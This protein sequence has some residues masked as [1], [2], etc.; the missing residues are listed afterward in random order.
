MKLR[1][2]RWIALSVALG[3]SPLSWFASRLS[4]QTGKANVSGTVRDAGSAV[5]PGANVVITNSETGVV[6][7][8]QTNDVGSY[9]LGALPRGPYTLVVEKEGFKKWTG[10]LEL[11]VGQNAVVDAVLN[12]GSAQEVVSVTGSAPVITTQ[13][14]EVSNVKDYERIRQLPLNGREITLLLNLTPGVEGEGSC[15]DRSSTAPCTSFRVN[16]SKVG[17]LDIT[18]DGISGIDRFGGGAARIEPGLDT[19]QEFRIETA[20]SDASYSRPSTVTIST[21]S[22]TNIFH[23]SLFETHRNNS[24]GLRVRRR[25]D[26]PDPE[27]GV[28]KP[29]QL[30]RNEYGASA[31]GPLFIPHVYDGRNKTFW[32]AAF[33]GLRGLQQS[34]NVNDENGQ[35]VP[36]EAMWNGDFS[37]AQDQEGNPITIYDPLTTD[38]NG[39]RQPFP[40]NIIPADRLNPLGTVLSSITARPSNTTNPYLGSNFVHFYPDRTKLWNLTLKADQ[41][42]GDKDSL[43]VRYTRSTRNHTTEGGVF[44]NPATAADGAGTSRSDDKIQ[45][46]AVTYNRVISNNFLNELLV[47][48]HRSFHDQGTLADFTDWAGELGLPNP[49]GVN[50]WPTFCAYNLGFYYGFCWD[51]DN[52]S[53]QALTAEV[54]D[55][56]ATWTKGKHTFKFGGRLRLEQNNVRELQQAQGSHTFV[57]EWTAQSALDPNDP[58]SLTPFT[59]DGLADLLLGLPTTMRNQYNRGYFYFRQ[60]EMGLYFNDSWKISPRL[61]LN[62]G[63]RWDKW[64]PYQEAQ[65]RLTTADINSISDPN[66]FEVI[67]PG[68]HDMHS[69]PGIPPSVLTSWEARGLTFNTARGVG[70]PDSLFA[71]DNN[72]FGPR[73]GAAF[74]ITSNTVLRGSYGEYFWTMPLSQLLQASRTNPPLNLLYRNAMDERNFPLNNFTAINQPTSGDFLPSATVDITGNGVISPGAQSEQ[75]WDGRNWKDDRIQ[76]WHVT[77]EHELPFQTAVRVSYLGTHGRDLEQAYTLNSLESAFNYATRTGQAPDPNA[78]LRRVNPNWNLRAKD[79]SGFSNSHS[80]QV[81]VERRFSNGIAFQGFYTF[82]RSLTTTDAGGFVPGNS[83]FNDVRLGAAPPEN[84]DILGEPNLSY[85]QRLRMVYLNSTEVPPHHFRFN[86]VVDLPFGKGKKIAGNASG[87][88]NSVIGGW[89][90]ATI[91]DWRSG[92]WRSVSGSRFQ[93]GNP[94][95]DPDQRLELTFNDK[96]QRLWFRGDFDPTQATNVT[97]GD[98]T[99]LVPVDRSQ[100]VIHPFGPDCDGSFDTNRLGV[101]L[102]DSSCFN[103]GTS[104]FFNPGRRANLLGPGAWNADIS[105]FKN[106]KLKELA[107]IRFTADFFNAFNHPNDIDPDATTGLQDLTRQANEPRIIQFSLRVDW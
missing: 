15:N 84:I 64:T 74:K 34:L 102:A 105:I 94:E 10:A 78:D 66:K 25:E 29:G 45:D 19:V 44:A 16:G 99:A 21:R 31:G 18:V 1:Q 47:G 76:Q 61:T 68:N 92:F 72:N 36:T 100:R 95:L 23:G 46:V 55:D 98:L 4:A 54:L 79:R 103:A 56:N 22:G 97:G 37:N 50:G 63:L 65:N 17:S 12:V 52:H 73:I 32:F 11:Y 51:A 81:E 28:F 3:L 70:Y 83:G 107:N 2:L 40:G 59:G 71:A 39:N 60:K 27:T 101:T 80:A 96:R 7:K 62:L 53:N 43:S 20:G 6:T 89:Q 75:V 42:F 5:V 58:R 90:V 86:G 93:A 82:I 41:H 88:L 85:D 8:A 38:A 33:E 67:T 69:L 35:R 48:V 91:G 57:G 26:I 9:Y 30:I 13:S 87:F 106:F 24:G 49:F 14:A 77:L 104:D